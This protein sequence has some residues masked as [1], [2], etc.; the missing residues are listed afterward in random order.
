L[1]LLRCDRAAQPSQGSGI[2]DLQSQRARFAT[3]VVESRRNNFSGD[4]K[5]DTGAFAP[6]AHGA[7][8]WM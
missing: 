6:Q 7:R 4:V 3:I 2:I 5:H 8:R 1:L